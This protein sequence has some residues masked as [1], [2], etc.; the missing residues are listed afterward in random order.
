MFVLLLFIL[1]IML[2]Q[3]AACDTPRGL[4]VWT[5]LWSPAMKVCSLRCR[6]RGL[7]PFSAVCCKYSAVASSSTCSYDLQ[8]TINPEVCFCTSEYAFKANCLSFWAT[9]LIWR[10]S[11]S[12]TVG[13][14]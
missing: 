3:T 10:C 6:S 7:S 2:F 1:Y 11:G 12:P 9:A 5:P 13:V 14:Y 4:K 8:H